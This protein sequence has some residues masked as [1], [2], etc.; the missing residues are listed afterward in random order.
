ML[1]LNQL[2]SRVG[3]AVDFIGRTKELALLEGLYASNRL[4]LVYLS[5]DKQIGKTALIKEFLKK[6][7]QYGYFCLRKST[8]SVNMAAIYTELG[9]QGFENGNGDSAWEKRVELLFQRALEDKLVLVL[10]CAEELEENF[11]ELLAL[12]KNLLEELGNR[13]RLLVIFVGEDLQYLKERRHSS[14]KKYQPIELKLEPIAYREVASQLRNLSNEEKV[15]LYGVTAGFP[16]YLKYVDMELSLKDNLQK[17]FFADGVP[18]VEEPLRI[19]ARKLRQPNIYHAILCSVACGAIRT[20]EISKA[21]NM[22]YNKL[23]KYIGVLVDMGLLDRVIP[24]DELEMQKQHKKTFYMLK[25]TMLLF[26]YKY[27]FPYYSEIELGLGGNIL[28]KKVLPELQEYCQ[29]I[30]PRICLDFC[31]QLNSM[32]SFGQDYRQLGWWWK[33]NDDLSTK[34]LYLL[35]LREQ[36]AMLISCYWKNQK[37]DLEEISELEELGEELK[38]EVKNYL[39]FSRRGFTDRAQ[40]LSA[41]N[42]DLRLISL[43]YLR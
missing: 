32:G 21:V 34:K 30:F 42:P 27:V 37:V 43:N 41:R 39:V 6:K 26:W 35:A 19:L 15:V 9:L 20:S 12:I 22:E 13:L 25:S 24:V 29:N 17:L 23:S 10:D 2:I 3:D 16:G 36:E 4:Q 31:R 40:E 5:G 38:T 18:L 11:P 8:A 33:S 7:K 1:L 28:R 14:L